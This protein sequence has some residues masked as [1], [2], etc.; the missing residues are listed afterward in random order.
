MALRPGYGPGM[1]GN[2]Q[3]W[4]L[5]SFQTKPKLKQFKCGKLFVLDSNTWY[6]ILNYRYKQYLLEAIILYER[7]SILTWKYIIV[8]NLA[9]ET[10]HPTKNPLKT[11]SKQ[12]NKQNIIKKKWLLETV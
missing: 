11:R 6:I 7:L 9:K 8:C 2:L 5:L 1:N 3:N 12:T 4:S 10:K